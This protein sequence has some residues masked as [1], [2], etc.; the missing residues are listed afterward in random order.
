M[1]GLRD[2]RRGGIQCGATAT[3]D[4]EAS[5]GLTCEVGEQIGVGDDRLATFTIERV[6]P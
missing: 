5:P 6:T 3:G 4:K 2:L 1:T